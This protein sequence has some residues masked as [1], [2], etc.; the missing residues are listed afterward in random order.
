MNVVWPCEKAAPNFAAVQSFAKQQVV[1]SSVTRMLLN[2]EN[3][4][5]DY[6]KR[7][8]FSRINCMEILKVQKRA[9]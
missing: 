6:S 9:L 4:E 7:Y 8:C 1:L 3:I 2:S 5:V